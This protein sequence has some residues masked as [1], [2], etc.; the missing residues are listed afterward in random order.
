MNFANEFTRFSA[1]Y[2]L[3]IVLFLV[4]LGEALWSYLTDRRN[5]F[6]LRVIVKASLLCVMHFNPLYLFAMVLGA[7]TFFIFLEYKLV[8]GQ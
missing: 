6:R 5:L 2:L 4:L 7:E 1:F 8:S 3:G